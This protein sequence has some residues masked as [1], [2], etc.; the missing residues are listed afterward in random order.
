MNNAKLDYT[1]K[2]DN[3][4]PALNKSLHII[5]HLSNKKMKIDSIWY[6]NIRNRKRAF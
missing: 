4:Q 1:N 5:T 2:P 3:N 6:T